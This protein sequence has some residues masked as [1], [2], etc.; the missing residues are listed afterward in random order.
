MCNDLHTY[1]QCAIVRKAQAATKLDLCE[2]T[3]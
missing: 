1:R 2:G 3:R